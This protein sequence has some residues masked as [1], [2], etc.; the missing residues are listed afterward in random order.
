MFLPF[1]PGRQEILPG[2]NDILK[3][4]EPHI[5][6]TYRVTSKQLLKPQEMA[7]IVGKVIGRKIKAQILPESMM[8]KMLRSYGFPQRDA[9]QVIHYVKDGH[10]GGFSRYAP[11]TT[12]A[13]IVGKPA[14][15]FETITRRYLKDNPMV[16]QSILNKLRTTGIMIKAM[17][18]SK[19]DMAKFEKEQGFPIF[20]NMMLS[21]DSKEWELAHTKHIDYTTNMSMKSPNPIALNQHF[22]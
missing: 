6:K 20:E 3:N 22:S 9:S 12:V 13:D 19:C 21:N 5:G 2:C 15:D 8:L 1:I 18:T 7:D 17:F 16:K 11:T 10:N 4:P 14:D